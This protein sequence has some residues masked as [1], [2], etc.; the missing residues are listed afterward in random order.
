M[1]RFS[2]DSVVCFFGDSI[3]ANGGWIRRIYDYYRLTEKIPCKFINCGVPGDNA[4]N[5]Q[6]RMEDTVF[7]HNPTDVVVAFGMNDVRIY[8]YNDDP[9]DERR[10][11][12]R[13]RAIDSCIDSLRSI[14]NRCAQ[15][16]VRVHFCT[17]TPYDELQN[18][19]APVLRGAAA[20][21]QEIG[22]R[23]RAM[24]AEFGGHVVDFNT[25]FNQLLLNLYKKDQTVIGPDRVHPLPEGHEFMGRVFL[26]DQGFDV[27]VPETLEQLQAMVAE[28]HDA[29]EEQ[30][31]ELETQANADCYIRWNACF[32]MQD[33][34][35]IDENLSRRIPNETNPYVRSRMES[36]A[37]DRVTAPEYREKL[38]QFLETVKI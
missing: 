9:L 20:A 34:Q 37:R 32:G 13:R 12:E 23:I 15:R 26:R 10:S 8:L 21:L 3:T 30:R 4:T 33:M 18:C 22:C 14:A 29:W 11:L 2:K 38:K 17:P 1:Y 16:N 5:G 28:P 19:D 7:I 25:P 24:A 36:F 27:A 31:F 6:F 35:I